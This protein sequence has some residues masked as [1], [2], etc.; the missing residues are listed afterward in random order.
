MIKIIIK[1]RINIVL[2]YIPASFFIVI[3]IFTNFIATSVTPV[4]WGYF[5]NKGVLYYPYSL[6]I[7]IFIILGFIT[8]YK[9]YLKRAN[10]EE[11][12]QAKFLIFAISIP[13][14]GGILSE[15]VLPLIDINFMPL[16]TT[17]TTLMSIIIASVIVKYNLMTPF[18]FSI[19]KKLTASFLTIVIVVS[20][21]SIFSTT[22]GQTL[23][24]DNI[25]S[26]SSLLAKGTMDKIDRSIT[27]RIE[28]F[29][30]LVTSSNVQDFVNDSNNEFSLIGTNEDINNYIIEIDNNWIHSIDNESLNFK[31]KLL[32]NN[33]SKELQKYLDLLKRIKLAEKKL[34][35]KNIR[36]D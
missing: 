6:Y 11:K 17:L 2:L 5:Q 31:E 7:I 20:T 30:L 8:C 36:F 22:Q 4:Y 16:S 26:G 21:I 14:I 27:N 13:L 15:V 32:N 12:I 9:F 35:C 10:K 33:L 1:K 25:G 34:V 29:E 24:Y 3:N 18:S 23:F 28:E 19:Q